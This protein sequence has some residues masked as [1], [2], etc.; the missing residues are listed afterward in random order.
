MNVTLVF[1]EFDSCGD[2]DEDPVCRKF[3]GEGAKTKVRALGD[4]LK[5]HT[6]PCE[7]QTVVEEFN[8]ILKD[9]K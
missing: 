8:E 6:A 3:L 4:L 2:G 9:K 7:S 1:T 5:M